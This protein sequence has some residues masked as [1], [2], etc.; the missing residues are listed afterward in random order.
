MAPRTA[1]PYALPDCA[2]IEGPQ[3][4][5]APFQNFLNYGNPAQPHDT[6]GYPQL[7]EWSRGQPHL[8]GHVLALDPARLDVAACG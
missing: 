5:A 1:S 6:R 8:R 2:A 3:G 4:I 7:T